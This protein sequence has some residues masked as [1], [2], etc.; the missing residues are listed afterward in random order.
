MTTQQTP[1]RNQQESAPTPTGF[2][3]WEGKQSPRSKLVSQIARRLTG[4]D[5]FPSDE[6]AQAFCDDLYR[7]DPVAERFVDDVY[8]GEIGRKRGREMLDE[9]LESTIDDVE[10]VPDSMRELFEEFERVPAWVDRDLVEEG[11]AIWR[12]WGTMLFSVAG[13]TTL[14]MYTEAAVAT[15]L[16]LAGGYA[17]D[18][19]MRRFTETARF[20]IDVS[21][22]GALLR[23]GSAGRATA[24]RVRVM[25]VSVRRRVG[26]HAEWDAERW[27][28]PICQS[29][30]LLTLIGGSVAPALALWLTGV[31]TTPR[32]M[33]ALLHFQRYMGH[34]LGVQP[35]WY[36]SGVRECLQIL[37]MT[38][39]SRSYDAGEH[40]AELIESFPQAF[41]PDKNS[42]GLRRL[43]E[44]YNYRIHVAYTALWMAPK[45]RARYQMPRAFP[46]VALPLLRFPAMAAFSLARRYIPGATGLV[47]KVN[48]KHRE[49]WFRAQMGA[50]EA[51]FE[52][53]SGLR[54]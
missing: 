19:A 2:R 30:M 21:E 6:K 48:K 36:P 53:S 8:F 24:M 43:R 44:E 25:H 32:E 49:N 33:R 31:L 39:A 52:A 12:R 45:T 7:G 1:A 18:N 3:Y 9:A 5:I 28:L 50:K 4:S 14:E 38:I 26:E 23:R 51:E 13:A 20:W 15:P 35:Q 10:G 11:A 41:E 40:G 22:P 16:S 54:R 42:R 34:L 47:D 46:W 27:G 37:A 29:Y 17:G